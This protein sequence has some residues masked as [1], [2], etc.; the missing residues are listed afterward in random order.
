[1]SKILKIANSRGKKPVMKDIQK[2]YDL[3]KGVMIE[4]NASE[5]KEALKVCDGLLWGILQDN[6]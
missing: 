2:A 5:G 3:I 4:L 1:M 6:K